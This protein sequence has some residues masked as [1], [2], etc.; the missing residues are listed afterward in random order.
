MMNR[1]ASAEAK[2]LP[3]LTQLLLPICIWKIKFIVTGKFFLTQK[4][5]KKKKKDIN[6]DENT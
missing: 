5:G 4:I 6:G 1:L 2:Q 3:L